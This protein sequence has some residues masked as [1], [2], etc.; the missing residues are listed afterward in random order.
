MKSFIPDDRFGVKFL[1]YS[2]HF[3]PFAAQ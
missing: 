3:Y 2:K 1:I